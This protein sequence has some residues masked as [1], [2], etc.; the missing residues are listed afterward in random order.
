MTRRALWGQMCPSPGC[1]P[2]SKGSAW[3]LRSSGSAVLCWW[4]VLSQQSCRQSG[5]GC[6]PLGLR[7][8]HT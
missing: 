8:D 1:V 7:L 4:W 2:G 5:S 3:Y 6:S